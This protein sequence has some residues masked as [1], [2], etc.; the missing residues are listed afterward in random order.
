MSIL[1]TLSQKK[2]STQ[3]W[4]GFALGI[5]VEL[6][7]SA[8]TSFIFQIV[9]ILVSVQYELDMNIVG[10]INLGIPVILL[11]TTLITVQ[12]TLKSKLFTIGVAVGWITVTVLSGLTLFAVFNLAGLK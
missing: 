9:M 2:P 7:V 1:T 12:K 8:I 5:G 11:I 4:L 10:A 6:A 3:F